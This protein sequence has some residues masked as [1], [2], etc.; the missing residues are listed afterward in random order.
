M[1]LLSKDIN[2]IY[3]EIE[4]GSS[5]IKKKGN[6]GE[7]TVLRICEEIYSKQGGI[8]YH[9]FSYKTDPSLAGNIK[10]GSNGKHYIENL[11]SFTEI[12]VLL[13][14]PYKIFPIEVKTYSVTNGKIVL[15]DGYIEGCMST[16][17]TPIHQNEMHCRHLYSH[18]FKCIPN[19]ETKYIAPI[20]VFVDRCKFEDKR[21]NWQKKYIPAITLD[22][23]ESLIRVLNKPEEYKLD[24][25]AVDRALTECSV[26][27]ELKLPLRKV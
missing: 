6:L 22:Y 13:V 5:D 7:K 3:R 10:S 1:S 9:S 11:S 26:G 20:V 21:S 2:K 14:T 12:D 25:E 17:K 24:L 8:L 15:T 19:G 23:L 4:N 27:C 16:E 18:I